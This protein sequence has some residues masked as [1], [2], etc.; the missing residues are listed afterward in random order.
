MSRYNEVKPTR[1]V[2]SFVELRDEDFNNQ[3]VSINETF[4]GSMGIDPIEEALKVY[5]DDVIFE[6]YKEML[7]GDLFDT[8]LGDR[9]LDLLPAKVEQLVENSKY[10]IVNEAYG[11]AMLSPI[12]GYTL[13]ILKKNM[14][15]CI[16][17]DIMMTEVP[18]SPVIKV[19]FERK[20]L[21]D[22]NGK[23]YYIPE[24]FYDKS[25]K[26]AS[27]MAKGVKVYNE[28]VQA[29]LEDYDLM[30]ASMGVGNVRKGQDS[31]AYDL[32]ISEIVF[33]GE[34]G[35]VTVGGLNIQPDIERDGVFYKEVVHN[36]E[37]VILVGRVDYYN[38]T[39]CCN[40]LDGSLVSVK[41]GGH[42]SNQFNDNSLDMD[43]ERT[44]HT[45]EIPEG[46]RLN[47]G[48]TIEKIKDWKAMANIDITPEVV[49]D[50]ATTLTQFED[51][52]AMDFLEGSLDRWKDKTDLP[53][54]YTKGFVQTATFDCNVT[55]GML[56]QSDYIEKELKFRFNK[57]ISSLKDILKTPEIMF[58]AYGHPNNIE[59]F[60]SA[61]KWVVDENSRVGG[62]QLD[63]KFGVM[64]ESGNRIHFISSL[65]V[66]EDLGI[67]IVAYPTTANHITFKHYKYSFNI[68][69]TYRHPQVD[70]VPNIMATH[71]YLSTE[72]LP[73]QAQLGFIN[74]EFGIDSRMPKPEEPVDPGQ[75]N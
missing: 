71:R 17:K 54:G 18:D 64:T 62:V 70:R 72:L 30:T 6:Q 23:K 3:L 48:L 61:V 34:G 8:Q 50:M 15:E 51:C 20:F 55:S 16:A 35:E 40:S 11:V 10:E 27:D 56:T 12:V 26:E 46:E 60:N 38:G 19:V 49:N 44:P 9:Y 7:L 31:F 45:W 2:G 57:L 43:R 59:L 14:L 1:V 39:V 36:G 52:N 33:N 58:V 32:H 13:P 24:I 67:R 5:K 25:F 41:F 28:A 66:A 42:V 63:Y 69:N 53:Y 4:K 68:E 75:G 47:T 65:K 22:K 21:K 37:R 73:V 29:P 74:N